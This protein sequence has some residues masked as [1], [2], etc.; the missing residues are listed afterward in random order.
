MSKAL[1]N[2]ITAV[3][4]LPLNMRKPIVRKALNSAIHKYADLHVLG[5][6][7]LKE[8]KG[9]ATIYISNHLS[10][11]DAPVINLYLRPYGIT[12]IAGVKIQTATLTRL[13]SETISTI[14]INPGTADKKAIRESVSLLKSGGSLVIFPEGSRSRSAQMM[15]A[16]KGFVLLARLSGTAI[17]PIGLAGT[18]ELV[19][20][21][22]GE[23]GNETMQ[24]AAVRVN[25]GKAFVLPSKEDCP[26]QDYNRFAADYCMRK[27]AALLPASY[28]GYYSNP[29]SES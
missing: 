7:N 29:E 18:E 3:S 12:F 9:K 1:N 10:N 13:I 16:S 22:D 15:E 21:R 2:I 19:P 24:E 28:R 11:V 8:R 14:N 4:K 17:V 26:I 25:F 5:L 20:I 23:M 6:E 27:I